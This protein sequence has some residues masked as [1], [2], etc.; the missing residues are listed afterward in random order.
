MIWISGWR[1]IL[2]Q[3]MKHIEILKNV[4]KILKN[5]QFSIFS[6]CQYYFRIIS[7][8]FHYLNFL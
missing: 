7:V 1:N 3:R 4:E 6:V 8:S 2:F 5:A